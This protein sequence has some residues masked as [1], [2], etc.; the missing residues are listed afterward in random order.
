MMKDKINNLPNEV[1]KSIA[2]QLK[3]LSWA[4]GGVNGY[5]RH[6]L[7]DFFG[8]ILVITGWAFLQFLSHY[9]I[10]HIKEDEKKGIKK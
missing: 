3:L 4:V 2:D 1:K 5:F 9:L 10:F 7:G 6:L 8:I